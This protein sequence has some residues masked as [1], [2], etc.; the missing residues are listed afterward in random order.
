MRIVVL[1]L[2]AV[3]ISSC[4]TDDRPVRDR[5]RS[6]V[7]AS[8]VPPYA[9]RNKDGRQ[10]WRRT[11]DFYRGREFA[12]LWLRHRRATATA[13]AL[14]A[15]VERA[16]REGLDPRVYDIAFIHERDG[17]R[18]T[19]FSEEDAGKIDV[20]LT[21]VYMQFAADLADGVSDL[22]RS[23][24][25]WHI[26]PRT[27]D[28][29]AHLTR[30]IA[31]G[32]IAESLD[33]LKP[34][35]REYLAL[36]ELLADYRRRADTGGPG[37]G[38]DGV[39]LAQRIK[40]IE[41]NMERW[42]WLPRERAARHILVNIPA[43]RLDVWEGDSVAL[44]M[45]VVVGKKDT[46]TPIFIDTLTHVVFSPYWN[47]PATIAKDE[48]LPSALRD[49]S[50]LQRTKME[51]LDDKG[52]VVDPG[53]ID[54]DRAAD[55]RFRQRP[56]KGNALGLVKF[57]FPN[58][59]NVYLHDT[60]TDSL[61]ARATRSFSHGCVRVEQP[62]VLAEYLLKDRPEWTRDTI[63][64]AMHAGEERTVKLRDPVPV[65]IGY[66]TVDITPDGKA[67][68]LPDVYGLDARAAATLNERLLQ[69]APPA[70]VSA[71]DR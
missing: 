56:G 53:S 59:F 42:R 16:G 41:L 1:V 37:A 7:E 4:G 65:Y 15:A 61:F 68:F 69:A 23:H 36:S 43:F 26:R 5:I 32:K 55:Y 48:T 38:P 31:D 11:R 30:A 35:N 10:L 2:A 6:E 57:M 8:S 12:P 58:E 45:R 60:P 40:Q 47:V 66:W 20:R 54:L 67:A 71:R 49:P 39:P 24:P 63:V 34:R 9:T 14:G 29:A 17:I 44:S 33:A 22:A 52:Q 18:R 19:R 62:Q 25:G 46:P 27:F 64:E 70:R 21:F 50:F 28:P 13:D 51:V 3:A